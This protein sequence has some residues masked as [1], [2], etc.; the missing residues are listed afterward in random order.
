MPTLVY[1]AVCR[2]KSQTEV[3]AKMTTFL[4]T[5]LDTF[6]QT[7][8]QLTV[9]GGTGAAASGAHLAVMTIDYGSTGA[10]PIPNGAPLLETLTNYYTSSLAKYLSCPVVASPVF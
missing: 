9:G 1:T 3:V 10:G 5:Q 8:L 7:L 6:M 4:G 2:N